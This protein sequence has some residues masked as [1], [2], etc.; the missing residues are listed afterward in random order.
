M[1]GKSAAS[2]INTAENKSTASEF[3]FLTKTMNETILDYLFAAC[4]ESS[5]KEKALAFL[6]WLI[7]QQPGLPSDSYAAVPQEYMYGLDESQQAIQTQLYRIMQHPNLM[8]KRKM[9][10]DAQDDLFYGPFNFNPETYK[11]VSHDQIR[12]YIIHRIHITIETLNILKPVAKTLQ[13]QKK[14]IIVPQLIQWV[15]T[16]T[17]NSPNPDDEPSIIQK[18]NDL[19]TDHIT[20]LNIDVSQEQIDAEMCSLTPASFFGDDANIL[21]TIFEMKQPNSLISRICNIKE[22]DPDVLNIINYIKQDSFTDIQGICPPFITVK[23][24]YAYLCQHEKMLSYETGIQNQKEIKQFC[25]RY[26][27][28]LNEN[29][30]PMSISTDTLEQ[31]THF[32]EQTKSFLKDIEYDFIRSIFPAYTPEDEDEI[33]REEELNASADQLLLELDELAREFPNFREYK[34]NEDKINVEEEVKAQNAIADEVPLEEFYEYNE[35]K[36]ILDRLKRL[37]EGNKLYISD[38]KLGDLFVEQPQEE[39]VLLAAQERHLLEETKEQHKVF[40][41]DNADGFIVNS[42]LLHAFYVTPEKWSVMFHLVFNELVH[43]LKA[44]YTEENIIWRKSAYPQEFIAQIEWLEKASASFQDEKSS[45][46]FTKCVKSF[47]QPKPYFPLLHFPCKNTDEFLDVLLAAKDTVE[48]KELK[49]NDLQQL[50]SLSQLMADHEKRANVAYPKIYNIVKDYLPLFVRSIEDISALCSLKVSVSKDSQSCLDNEYFTLKD[51]LDLFVKNKDD[52]NVILPSFR[53]QLTSIIYKDFQHL[54][55]LT[56]IADF[57]KVSNLVSSLEYYCICEKS[58]EQIRSILENKEGNNQVDNFLKISAHL[59]TQ[60]QVDM[61]RNFQD[62]FTDEQ[63]IEILSRWP[64]YKA[65][66]ISLYTCSFFSSRSL[67][68]DDNAIYQAKQIIK[69]FPEN[70]QVEIYIKLR[71]R[72][73]RFSFGLEDLDRILNIFS[74]SQQIEAFEK[75]LLNDLFPHGVIDEYFSKLDTIGI[76]LRY[77]TPD[78]HLAIFEIFNTKFPTPPTTNNI[79][80]LLKYFAPDQHLEVLKIIGVPMADMEDVLPLLGEEQRLA[81]AQYY[82]I[83]SDNNTTHYRSPG[84]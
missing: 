22:N 67:P 40:L 36:N 39:L 11:T 75:C 59:N 3:D 56:D 69:C 77:F 84:R 45:H 53:Y 13:E 34:P 70:E 58:K 72:L 7:E 55:L 61:Y 81:A 23:K 27:K 9:A 51:R 65:D 24:A 68:A 20:T 4:F 25:E 28:E 47:E 54:K 8:K 33:K 46:I 31:L 76:I 60:Q 80:K 2:A 6:K 18:I 30:I 14:E 42:I 57:I 15:E 26:F 50:P 10:L 73:K 43:Q 78:K 41:A 1:P 35:N 79:E 38:Q 74:P 37:H 16:N 44:P 21:E 29:K 66:F 5:N 19:I 12:H 52:F 82:K 71:S 49:D 17:G 32:I 83:D 64:E 62:I 63:Q 48:F